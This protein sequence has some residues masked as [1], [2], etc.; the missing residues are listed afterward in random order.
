VIARLNDSA[1]VL[2]DLNFFLLIFQEFLDDIIRSRALGGLPKI[3]SEF[4][5][6][7][8]KNALRIFFPTKTHKG[9][10]RGRA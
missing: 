1:I 5:K 4:L 9:L 7:I 2:S 8:V 3:V 10:L 6:Y